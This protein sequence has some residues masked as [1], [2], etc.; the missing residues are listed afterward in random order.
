MQIV[1]NVNV[2]IIII[3]KNITGVGN[4]HIDLI[5]GSIADRDRYSTCTQN[6]KEER[7][8]RSS[9]IT[10]KIF[11]KNEPKNLMKV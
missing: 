1:S 8:H 11:V 7:K 5:R 10:P 2:V 9:L 6:T 3:G 4:I